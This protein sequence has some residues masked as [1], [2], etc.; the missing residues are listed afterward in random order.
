MNGNTIII[1]SSTIEKTAAFPVPVGS[2]SLGVGEVSS[3][4]AC[5][6]LAFSARLYP[7]W[8]CESGDVAHTLGFS[9]RLQERTRFLSG[10]AGDRKLVLENGNSRPTPVHASPCYPTLNGEC[11]L[12]RQEDLLLTD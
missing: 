4:I 12:H 10:P 5:S 7:L 3:V 8:D 1:S 6:R 9:H 2:T 11:G